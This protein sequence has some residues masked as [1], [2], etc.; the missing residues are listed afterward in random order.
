LN[1]QV[2]AE[3][4]AAEFRTW[5][6]VNRTLCP[7][8]KPVPF[9]EPARP[10]KSTPEVRTMQVQLLTEAPVS[11]NTAGRKLDRPTTASNPLWED[12]A[13]AYS[14]AVKAPRRKRSVARAF[15]STVAGPAD[16][17]TSPPDSRPVGAGRAGA[18]E[19]RKGVSRARLMGAL[20]YGTERK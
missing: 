11:R 14:S 15:W 9:H 7:S 17:P 10:R 12:F 13:L 16:G 20:R 19:R 8:R 6:L 1:T 18:V 3:A 2:A 4:T 5:W